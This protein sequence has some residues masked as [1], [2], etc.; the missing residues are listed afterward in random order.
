MATPATREEMKQYCLRAIGQPVNQINVDDEQLEDRIDEALQYYRDYHYDAT[1]H[2]YTSA[3]I[4]S[5]LKTDGYLTL[6]ESV[7]SVTG[8]WRLPTTFASSSLFN[9]RYHFAA[10]FNFGGNFSSSS[11]LQHYWMAME[12]LALWDEILSGDVRVR[13]KRHM[14]RLYID[15]DWDTVST[16][17]YLIYE[18]YATLDPET[19][20]EIYNDRWLLKY[21]TQLFKRQWG[22]NLKKFSGIQMIGGLSFDGKEIYDE[23]ENEIRRMEDEMINSYSLPVFDLTG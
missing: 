17:D 8:V 1:E 4:T 14:D 15:A 12:N 3:V 21:T 6:P 2:I 23:A 7:Q 9:V 13:Y 19:W 10:D 20:T 16:G 18:G 22:Q 11:K 5:T